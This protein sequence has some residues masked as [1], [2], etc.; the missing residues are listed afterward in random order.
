MVE[1]RVDKDLFQK[2]GCRKG[3][4]ESNFRERTEK[5]TVKFEFEALREK[6]KENFKTIQL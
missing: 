1:I 5:G 3:K 4:E 2:T 6:N